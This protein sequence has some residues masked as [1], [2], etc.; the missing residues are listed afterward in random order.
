MKTFHFFHK[1][2]SSYNNI[3][4]R[5]KRL[6]S[7]EHEE[8]VLTGNMDVFLTCSNIN[9]KINI[10]TII[11][12]KEIK[13]EPVTSAIKDYPSIKTIIVEDDD[14]FIT[15]NYD[16]DVVF[17]QITK[18]VPK[19]PLCYSETRCCIS[20]VKTF[21]NVISCK[22]KNARVQVNI[23]EREISTLHSYIIQDIHVTLNH[24]IV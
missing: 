1:Y 14:S 10:S 20:R 21:L 13:M 17:P 16:D 7:Y 8:F 9:T 4:T 6:H 18:I 15:N 19:I 2:E 23:Y 12:T 11:V 5:M 24:I 3:F 22:Y